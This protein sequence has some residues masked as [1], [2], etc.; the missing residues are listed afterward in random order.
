MTL[1]EMKQKVLTLIEEWSPGSAFLTEDPDIQAKLHAVINQIA[2]ELARLRKIPKYTAIPVSAGDVLDFEAI[3]KAVGYALYQIDLVSGVR[4]Q[5]RAGGTV[6]KILESGTVEIDCFV[7]PEP[8]TEK[9][10]DSYEFQL[11][12]DALEIMPYGVAGDLLKSDASA[13]YGRVYSQ[14]YEQLLQLLD[15]RYQLG[16]IRIEGGVDV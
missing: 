13:G 16:S 7:Y 1:K 14:R 3:E 4:Y 15:H 8:I 12:Q 2:F 5:P 9:T 11:S 10:K 6:L